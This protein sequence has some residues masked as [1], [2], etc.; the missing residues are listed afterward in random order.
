MQPESKPIPMDSKYSEGLLAVPNNDEGQPR[1]IVPPTEIKAKHWLSYKLMKTFIIK[2]NHV[3][4]LCVLKA[5]CYRP[6]LA[7]DIDYGA[8]HAQHVQPR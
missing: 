4:V 6:N 1:I 5:S 3:K 7:K 2:Q 8:L